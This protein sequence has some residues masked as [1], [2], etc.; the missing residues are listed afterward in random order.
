MR[1]SASSLPPPSPLAGAADP[2]D[3]SSPAEDPLAGVPE[4]TSYQAT[5]EDDKIA[6][7]KLTADSV[8]QMR[9]KANS[10]LLWHPVNLAVLVAVISIFSRYLSTLGKDWVAVGMA[11]SG[12]LVVYFAAA[13]LLTQRY[14]ERAEQLNWQWLGD[15]DV[16]VTKFGEEIIGA[17]IIE[18]VSGE[19]RQKRRKAWRGEIKGWAVRMKYRGKGVGTA[20]LEDAVREAKSKGAESVEFA[21]DH[22]GKLALVRIM[23]LTDKV[24][25]HHKSCQAFIISRSIDERGEL[26]NCSRIYSRILQVER[27][28]R[29]PRFLYRSC[30]TSST[31]CACRATVNLVG[32]D[33]YL[34]M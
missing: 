10:T 15:A 16:F 14:I 2:T 31:H 23:T 12:A 30:S 6:A 17:L 28:S 3:V 9:Q 5:T 19:S 18:W 24:Q 25:L 29:D 11:V 1:G 22:A 34:I 20:L 7:L 26:V 21:V 32:I 13:R 27:G 4:L 33:L 8:A